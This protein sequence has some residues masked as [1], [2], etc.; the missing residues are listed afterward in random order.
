MRPSLRISF[1][2]SLLLNLRLK[3]RALKSDR[4]TI[5][6]S[7]LV[8]E[9]GPRHCLCLIPS[10]HKRDVRVPQVK[11]GVR[12]ANGSWRGGKMPGRDSVRPGES[13]QTGRTECSFF[14]LGCP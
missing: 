4:N 11:G 7:V 10:H 5:A 9:P 13:W 1:F 12:A 6:G 8:G 2:P 14:G 3:P